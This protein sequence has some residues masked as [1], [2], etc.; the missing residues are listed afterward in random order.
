M[1]AMSQQFG[2]MDSAKI[3]EDFAA[4]KVGIEIR[5]SKL[6]WRLSRHRC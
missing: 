5:L 6:E 1:A 2:L 3:D 4:G